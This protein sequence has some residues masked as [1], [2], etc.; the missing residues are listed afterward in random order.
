MAA[1]RDSIYEAL[2]TTTYFYDFNPARI[3]QR[4]TSPEIHDQMWDFHFQRVAIE[5]ALTHMLN[6]QLPDG[7]PIDPSLFSDTEWQR[8]DTLVNNINRAMY[9]IYAQFLGMD[10]SLSG[11]APPH[12][13]MPPERGGFPHTFGEFHS[14]G[15]YMDSGTAYKAAQTQRGTLTTDAQS[16]TRYH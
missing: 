10:L 16:A 13:N 7:T 14:P 9:T 12:D 8:L 15:S 4:E 1:I 11:K 5:E 2:F 3:P 6:D